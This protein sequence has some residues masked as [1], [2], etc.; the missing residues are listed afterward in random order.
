MVSLALRQ[1]KDE[2]SKRFS[3]PMK[4]DQNVM[5]EGVYQLRGQYQ[6]AT[7]MDSSDRSTWKHSTD[8]L[9]LGLAHGVDTQE[10]SHLMRTAD[11]PSKWPCVGIA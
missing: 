8:Q 7:G 11:I 5:A 4:T 9:E 3:S 6:V 2:V 1:A 10:A